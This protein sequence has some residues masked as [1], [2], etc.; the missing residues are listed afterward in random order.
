MEFIFENSRSNQ[1]FKYMDILEAI[2]NHTLIM[3]YY[4][5]YIHEFNHYVRHREQYPISYQKEVCRYSYA[6]SN[7]AFTFLYTEIKKQNDLKIQDSFLEIK[8][9]LKKTKSLFKLDPL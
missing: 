6:F 7:T 1:S 2:P 5:N 3:N 9:K 8:K 4:P